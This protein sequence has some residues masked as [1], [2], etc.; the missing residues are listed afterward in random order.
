MYVYYN[1]NNVWL[2]RFIY[3][4]ISYKQEKSLGESGAKLTEGQNEPV[5]IYKNVTGENKHYALISHSFI[6]L[7][8]YVLL[9]AHFAPWRG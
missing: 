2:L 7:K 6:G 1:N 9:K 5:K 3:E 4:N 8:A